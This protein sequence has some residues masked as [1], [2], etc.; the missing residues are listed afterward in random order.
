MT[1]PRRSYDDSC[2]IARALDVVGERWSLLIVR[3]L[4]LGPRRFGQLRAGLPDPSPNVLSQ[5]LRELEDDGVV[6]RYVLDPPAGVAVYEL[7]ERGRALEPI[8]LE[9]GRWGSAVP[10]ATD[11]ELSVVSMLGALKAM[12]DPGAEPAVTYA[13][14]LAGEWYGVAI[15]DGRIDISR[16]CPDAPDATFTTD[17]ATLRSLAFGGTTVRAAEERGTLAVTGGRRAANR[18]AKYFRP[19]AA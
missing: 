7:T 12:F 17:V 5:R 19:P 4:M 9:L 15:E 11:R 14:E 8:L 6:R 10:I 13:V 16:G 2:G 1:S 18:F 3:E